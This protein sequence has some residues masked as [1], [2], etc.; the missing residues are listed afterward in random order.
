MQNDFDHLFNYFQFPPLGD[1]ATFA[2]GLAMIFVACAT[3]MASHALLK[4]SRGGLRTSFELL[5]AAED[6]L[7]FAESGRGAPA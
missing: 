1:L 2:S 7:D 4:L 6:L 3:G 5:S